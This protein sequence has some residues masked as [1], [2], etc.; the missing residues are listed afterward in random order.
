MSFEIT[1]VSKLR[2]FGSLRP[3]AQYC[4]IGIQK[5]IIRFS[6]LMDR[7]G[8]GGVVGETVDDDA[9]HIIVL[10]ILNIPTLYFQPPFLFIYRSTP[11]TN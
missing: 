8:C 3:G 4:F 2:P 6:D 1:R 10:R 11:G 9:A 5:V 7:R